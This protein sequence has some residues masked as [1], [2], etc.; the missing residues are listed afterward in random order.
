MERFP[1]LDDT[2]GAQRIALLFLGADGHATYD[3]LFCQSDSHAPFAILLQ[4]HGFGGN[5]S[6]FGQ[7]GLMCNIAMRTNCLPE[8]LLVAEN[9]HAWE[10]YTPIR[11]LDP[12]YGGMHQSSRRLFALP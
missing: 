7:G 11:D 12:T 1:N 4:D 2:H 3:A 8:L 6:D 10:G 9:T 5:F